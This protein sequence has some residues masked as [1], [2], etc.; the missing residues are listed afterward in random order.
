MAGLEPGPSGLGPPLSHPPWRSASVC[1]AGGQ[2][3]TLTL[4]HFRRSGTN[5]RA[6]CGLLFNHNGRGRRLFAQTN[7]DIALV[8][9]AIDS[10]QVGGFFS[11]GEIGPVGGKT[12]VH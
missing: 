1:D 9:Q 2:A 4:Q 11:Q 3:A 7:H 5:V 10:C 8:N 12:S 6:A